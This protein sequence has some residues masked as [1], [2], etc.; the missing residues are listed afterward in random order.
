MQR[1]IAAAWRGLRPKLS[2]F[3][4]RFGYVTSM[5]ALLLLVGAAA[6]IYRGRA[7]QNRAPAPTPTPQ[8]ALA[9]SLNVGARKEEEEP[10]FL[11][12]LDGEV[13]GE[14]RPDALVWSDTLQLW[15]THA[16]LDIAAPLG[17]AVLACADGTVTEA[18]RDP[19]LGYTVRL[20]HEDGYE[21]LYACLQSAEMVE[22]GQA[23]QMGDVIGAVG[24]E[25]RRRGGSGRAPALCLFPRRR[26]HAAAAGGGVSQRP[27]AGSRAQRRI[28][29]YIDEF[30]LVAQ[31]LAQRALAAMPALRITAPEAGLSTSC[32]ASMRLSLRRR[33]P[34]SSTRSSASVM[35]PWFQ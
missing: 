17:T 9:S 29:V 14:Y 32:C 5:A 1:A 16:A 10:A 22:V 30:S 3:W 4:N 34:K 23:V 7:A 19:L 35:M 20:E 31:P 15:Q 13:V 18:Y 28:K 26:G 25:R 8:P 27:C 12:P 24:G 6:A 21:S 33:K 2:A 11:P